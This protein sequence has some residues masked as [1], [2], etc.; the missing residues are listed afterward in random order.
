M[1][2]QNRYQLILTGSLPPRSLRLRRYPHN[3]STL[4]YTRSA[5]KAVF[6]SVPDA[7]ARKIVG[8]N[9]ARVFGLNAAV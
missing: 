1:G 4:G 6:D 8:G 9:A 5:V 3:E 7:D 2:S